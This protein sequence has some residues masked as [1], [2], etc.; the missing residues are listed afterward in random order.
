MNH[1]VLTLEDI[2]ALADGQ[3]I[4]DDTVRRL[5]EWVHTDRQFAEPVRHLKALAGDAG[6]ELLSDGELLDRDFDRLLATEGW[7]HP[8][9]LLDPEGEVGVPYPELLAIAEAR[10]E[11]RAGRGED[12][13]PIETV[14]RKLEHA[15][16][17]HASVESL[18][19]QVL[20]R[21]PGDPERLLEQALAEVRV[22]RRK[23][24][25]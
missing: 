11:A 3:D 25:E 19:D 15:A 7:E 14:R 22:R 12:A 6:V 13:A 2:A 16:R 10:A 5:S 17:P 21:Q 23:G 24:G 20:E 8:A 18:V 1:P 4:S 9:E